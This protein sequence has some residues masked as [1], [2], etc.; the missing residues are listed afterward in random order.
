MEFV[1]FYG[2]NFFLWYY[3]IMLFKDFMYDFDD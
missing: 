1:W 2:E 3:G